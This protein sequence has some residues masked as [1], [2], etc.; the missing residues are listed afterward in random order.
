MGLIK[1]PNGIDFIIKSKPLTDIERKEIS[2]FIRLKKEQ[3]KTLNI[4]KSN[5]KPKIKA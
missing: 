4:K 5:L 2:D 1:E 3:N